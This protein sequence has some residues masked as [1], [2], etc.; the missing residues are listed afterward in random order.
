MRS[1]SGTGVQRWAYSRMETASGKE[2]SVSLRECS[3]SLAR[4]RM[5]DSV[6]SLPYRIEKWCACVWRRTREGGSFLHKG[7]AVRLGHRRDARK[8]FDP[9]AHTADEGAAVLVCLF[10]NNSRSGYLRPGGFDQRKQSLQRTSLGKEVVND[11]NPVVRRQE[12][13]GNIAVR[14]ATPMPDASMVRIFVTPASL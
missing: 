7:D 12:L 10:N 4:C 6:I 14:Q 9:H 11:Q 5:S 3:T 13:A 8:A 1:P 2:A